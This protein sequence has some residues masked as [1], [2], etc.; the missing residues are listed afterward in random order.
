MGT[1]LLTGHLRQSVS[2]C[3]LIATSDEN[4]LNLVFLIKA[5]ESIGRRDKDSRVAENNLNLV[6]LI[7]SSES[8]GRRD[9]V[10]ESRSILYSS[11][12]VYLQI[13]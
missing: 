12:L 11:K 10:A 1:I 3:F 9:K 13:G 7:K 2:Y 4:N 8:I 6:F 5:S